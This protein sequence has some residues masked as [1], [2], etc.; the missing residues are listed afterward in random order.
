M[1]LTIKQEKFCQEYVKTSNKS[2]AYRRAYNSENMKPETINRKAVELFENGNVTA[3]VEELR[4]EIEEKEL[5]TLTESINKDLNLISTYEAALEVL[6]DLKAKSED[7]KAAERTIKHIG[8]SGY[9]SAQDRLSKKYGWFEKD[10][11]QK[12]PPSFVVF[13]AR[14]KE[15]E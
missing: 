4:N 14:T 9:S 1:S 13:D 15:K 8:S 2:E 6:Q 12:V 7:I 10:N 5:Y 11:V 3:R